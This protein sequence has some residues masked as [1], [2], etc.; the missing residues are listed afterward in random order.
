M[1]KPNV[2]MEF[3]ILFEDEIEPSE[4]EPIT[5]FFEK[6]LEDTPTFGSSLLIQWMLFA[7]LS[8]WRAFPWLGELP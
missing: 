1:P 6:F 8:S 3:E 4:D 2:P 5:T 7:W